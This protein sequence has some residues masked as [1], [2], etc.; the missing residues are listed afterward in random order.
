MKRFLLYIVTFVLPLLAN[1]Q[2]T[3][4]GGQTVSEQ[5]SDNS[6]SITI[7]VKAS[8]APH[9]YVWW[10]GNTSPNGGYPGDIMTETTEV[11]NVTFFYKT[12]TPTSGTLNFLLN[13]GGDDTKSDDIKGVT[14]DVFYEFDGKGNTKDVT[15]QYKDPEPVPDPEMPDAPD[16]LPSYKK[17]EICAFFEVPASITSYSE[18]GAWVWSGNGEPNYTGGKDNWPGEICEKIE[19]LSDN[20]KT[21]WKWTYTGELTEL[22]EYIIFNDNQK[23]GQLQTDNM[24]FVNGGYYKASATNRVDCTTGKVAELEGESEDILTRE[25]TANQY[26][27]IYLPYAVSATELAQL[28]GDFYEYT[29]EADGVLTFTGVKELKAW[30]PYVY[31]ASENGKNLAPLSEKDVVEKVSAEVKKGNFTFKGTNTRKN[32]I[33]NKQETYYGYRATDGTF[34]KVGSTKGANIDAW[35]AYF[36][37]STAG[38]AEAKSSSF[39]GGETTGINHVKQILENAADDAVY[40][41]DGKRMGTQNLPKGLYIYKGK[42]LIVK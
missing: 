34:V 23:N 1:A 6:N 21:V 9:L 26:A 11:K 7:Y 19:S 29:S 2:G 8:T 40:T 15:A 16:V 17:G 36:I 13:G 35:K 10:D 20:E 22:P 32:L 3:N 12:F 18:V 25:F 37:T 4:L 38:G 5:A 31:I 42:K 14:S 28:K 24:K 39:V 27:T 33:T 41:I 30:T